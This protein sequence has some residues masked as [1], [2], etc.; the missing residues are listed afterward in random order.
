MYFEQKIRFIK[1][2]NDHRNFI[3]AYMFDYIFKTFIQ[4]L[5]ECLG[6]RDRLVSDKKEEWSYFSDKK[7]HYLEDEVST[8]LK[9]I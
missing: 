6:Q 5:D 7:C 1:K 3:R 8:L 2:D 4:I 9:S